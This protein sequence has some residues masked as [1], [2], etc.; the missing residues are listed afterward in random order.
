[1]EMQTHKQKQ[2]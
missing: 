2:W 1:M